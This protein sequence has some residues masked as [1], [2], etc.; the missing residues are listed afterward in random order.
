[1]GLRVINHVM[2]DQGRKPASS[3]GIHAGQI[4]ALVANGT[5]GVPELARADRALVATTHGISAI[6]GIA[7]DDAITTGNTQIVVNPVSLAFE[8]HSTRRLGD[9]QD[10]VVEG[11]TNWTDT[12]TPRRG[13]T[14]YSGGGE[15]ATDKY[16]ALF[17]ANAATTD[18]A[19]APAFAVND[20]MTY[21]SSTT[22]S[23][24]GQ[25]VD[26][27]ATA[28]VNVVARVTEGAVSSCLFVRWLPV[29]YVHP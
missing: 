20:G 10:E 5:T 16:E 12:G 9:F 11:V 29:P 25:F 26:D 23:L 8:S 4:V 6:V 17:A 15:F 24:A 19:A 27:G 28:T 3:S 22:N 2:I 18:A 1:M 7:G 14:V 21:G 13:V